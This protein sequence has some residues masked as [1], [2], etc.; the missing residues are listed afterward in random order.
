MRK[1]TIF[2]VAA[3]FALAPL[4]AMP[5]FQ[6]FLP[7]ISGEY[8]YYRDNT[9]I[10][11][12]Y[13]GLLYYDAGTVQIRYYA[14][15]DSENFLPEKDIAILIT[16]NPDSPHWDMTGERIISAIMPGT[17]DMDIVNYLH[18]FLYE[19]SARRIKAGEITEK[20]KSIVQDYEQFGGQ[21]TVIFDCRIPMF[22]IR[23]IE[24]AGKKPLE[25]VTIGQLRDSFDKSF[26]DFKGFPKN[27][28]NEKK[29]K[30]TKI[31]KSKAKD[32][33][34]EYANQSVTLDSDWIHPMENVWMFGDDSIVTL[35]IIPAFDDENA[36]RNNFFVQR[37]ILESAQNSYTDFSSLD[38]QDKNSVKITARIFQAETGKS[39]FS[40]KIISKKQ[41]SSDFDYFSISTFEKP[42][43]ENKSYYQKIIK[44]YSN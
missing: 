23:G 26:D 24:A 27:P 11:E 9:F 7:D 5:G 4:A 14:P 33:K 43:T 40:T 30:S 39:V 41:D 8:V 21:V 6:S 3:F 18:D 1:I 38:I 31:K 37:R 29:S 2:A 10:R 20:S 32:V 15:Q 28:G 42:W 17:E 35:G 34:C 44:S 12:S 16:V 19:F 13:V 22:N 36:T 25:C